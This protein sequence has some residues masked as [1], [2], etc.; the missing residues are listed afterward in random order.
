[1][2]WLALLLAPLA[3][4]ADSEWDAVNELLQGARFTVNGSLPPL[5][6]PVDESVMGLAVLKANVTAKLSGPFVLQGFHVGGLSLAPRTEGDSV[7]IDLSI[8]RL[9][10]SAYAERFELDVDGTLTPV[11]PKIPIPLALNGTGSLNVTAS[12][13]L[14]ATF[15]FSGSAAAGAAP[16]QRL[17]VPSCNAQNT[18]VTATCVGD[19][20]VLPIPGQQVEVCSLVDILPVGEI[21]CQLMEDPGKF[22]LSPILALIADLFAVLDQPPPAP[23][24]VAA[25]EEYLRD[26][27]GLAPLAAHAGALSNTR[28]ILNAVYGIPGSP[29][30]DDRLV[31]NQIFEA[32]APH[33]WRVP[34]NLSLEVP[35][36]GLGLLT[37]L[38]VVLDAAELRMGHIT[39]FD[40]MALQGNYST[41]NTIGFE[42][43]AIDLWVNVSCLTGPGTQPGPGKPFADR[44]HVAINISDVNM[45]TR[46]LTALKPALL[47]PLPLGGFFGSGL[48]SFA[49]C[50]LHVLPGLG[51]TQL[52]LAIGRLD[53]LE[54]TGQFVQPP[55]GASGGFN[56]LVA[57]AVSSLGRLYGAPLQRALP[58]L[59][60]TVL[61]PMLDKALKGLVANN[62]IGCSVEAALAA[63][64]RQPAVVDFKQNYIV[65]MVDFFVNAIAGAHPDSD[66]GINTVLS[67]SAAALGHPDGVFRSNSTSGG[68]L[69][70]RPVPATPQDV[71]LGIV[72]GWVGNWTVRPGKYDALEMLGTGLCTRAGTPCHNLATQLATRPG[73]PLMVEADVRLLVEGSAGH[74][75]D[76]ARVSMGLDG[77]RIGLDLQALVEAPALAALTFEEAGKTECLLTAFVQDGLH[78]TAATMAV[79]GVTARVDCESEWHRCSGTRLAA[80][81]RNLQTPKG[82]ATL[83]RLINSSLVHMAGGMRGARANQAL[84]TVVGEAMCQNSSLPHSSDASKGSDWAVILLVVVPNVL[85]FCLLVAIT[86]RGFCRRR[87]R[88]AEER[89]LAGGK[90]CGA[91]IVA[92]APRCISDYDDDDDEY[93]EL[94]HWHVRYGFHESL[95]RHPAISA[96]LQYLI[97]VFLLAALGLLISA[98]TAR[99][100]MVIRADLVF[101]GDQLRVVV[102]DYTTLSVIKLG[103]TNSKM[104]FFGPFVGLTSGAFPYMKLMLL[105]WLWFLP[106]CVMSH[107]R[108]L[109]MLRIMDYTCKWSLVDV[110]LSAILSVTIH[111]PMQLPDSDADGGLWVPGLVSS[112]AGIDV[113]WGAWGL[114]LSQAINLIVGQVMVIQQRNLIA[115]LEAQERTGLLIARNRDS[116][117]F[118]GRGK[119]SV[120]L[121]SF[122]STLSLA[123]TCWFAHGAASC[124]KEP[125]R[126]HA[127]SEG[128]LARMLAPFFHHTGRKRVRVNACG[129]CV[130]SFWVIVCI[131]LVVV[132]SILPIIGFKQ[133]G[134]VELLFPYFTVS[135]GQR[136]WNLFDL[137]QDFANSGDDGAKASHVLFVVLWFGA[138][139]VI[140]IIASSS[141]LLM[142]VLPLS[143]HQHKVLLFVC[144]CLVSWSAVDV[145]VVASGIINIAGGTMAD[146]T[147]GNKCDGIDSDLAYAQHLGLWELA[148]RALKA[149][150][151][152]RP[153]WYVLI[154]MAVVSNVCYILVHKAAQ[155]AISDREWA[156]DHPRLA[157]ADADEDTADEGDAPPLRVP[158]VISVEGGTGKPTSPQES[159]GG[160]PWNSPPECRGGSLAR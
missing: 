115:T 27:E 54:A 141:L 2:R 154:A 21:A 29:P 100:M 139:F 20:P 114:L 36:L 95:F 7:L 1:M 64:A 82:L 61:G 84:D 19:F 43:L 142:W 75:D 56:A 86:F 135:L 136:E 74:L 4:A 28:T 118:V 79:E 45:T 71:D 125:L 55:L 137:I 49:G 101:G 124:F 68:V 121:G 96:K 83:T 145:F 123:S 39:H 22:G 77:A 103:W 69:V 58:R 110:F 132:G 30:N 127:F 85:L 63:A 120:R 8:S 108:R 159:F 81:D 62:P 67:R 3:A 40:L 153:G 94:S 65:Q 158:D 99:A 156:V 143:L 104:H 33:G 47:R 148:P 72:S 140:P 80:L 12:V 109:L 87:A 98:M 9:A 102:F 133:T 130:L 52:D 13:D 48:V 23:Q 31:I 10:L 17:A 126:G 37:D 60:Q 146:I 89:P 57:A 53:R 117:S 88:D 38:R 116:V 113:S 35:P 97:P 70:D 41:L 50:L 14:A 51:L 26:V 128:L 92:A 150:G 93:G 105:M 147:I 6:L 32:A 66:T 111:S 160:L 59:S 129:R 24:P 149:E 112:T 122:R 151:W 78:T 138:V 155:D 11:F 106:T 44:I 119:G 25:T 73:F 107:K 46:L 157:R 144:E 90:P 152:P 91:E 134:L 131:A 76:W 16:P 5:A 42:W 34:L 18:K 15:N